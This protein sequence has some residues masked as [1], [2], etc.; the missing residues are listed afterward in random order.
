MIQVTKI[1]LRVILNGIKSKM[2]PVIGS[3]ECGFIKE[4]GARNAT[5]IFRML[6]EKATEVKKELYFCFAD[7]EKAFD[8][9]K[10]VDLSRM[11]EQLDSDGKDL[12]LI[13]NLYLKQ[14]AAVRVSSD[15]SETWITKR[16]VR[17]GCMMPPDVFNYYSEKI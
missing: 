12:N 17:R 3:E 4:K 5:F 8:R 9:V 14:E 6:M 7:Y 10:H 1:M 2:L 11:L 15:E 16:G 13:R